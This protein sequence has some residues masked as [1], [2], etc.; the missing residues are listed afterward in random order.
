MTFSKNSLAALLVF[1]FALPGFA[2]KVEMKVK[3]SPAGSFTITGTSL[4]GKVIRKGSSIIVQ[5]VVLDLRSLQSGMELRDKH[6]QEY[7]ETSKFPQAVLLKAVGKDAK[8]VGDLKIRGIVKRIE[9][10]FEDE[11]KTAKASFKVNMSDFKIKK[12]NYMGLGVND[13]ITV[14][15]EGPVSGP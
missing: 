1:A 13:E 14:E 3:L 8:F 11:G 6:V 15:V 7:F 9:G 10:S 2:Q 5:N 12:A 4:S